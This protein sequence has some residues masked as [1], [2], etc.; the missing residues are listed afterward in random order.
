MSEISVIDLTSEYDACS[1]STK[2]ETPKTNIKIEM[3]I[4]TRQMEQSAREDAF[5]KEYEE[6][7][8]RA[9]DKVAPWLAKCIESDEETE[10][11][12]KIEYSICEDNLIQDETIDEIIDDAAGE[13]LRQTQD[14][15]LKRRAATV[16]WPR[17]L[18]EPKLPQTQSSDPKL[19]CVP[20][21]ILKRPDEPKRPPSRTCAINKPTY[22]PYRT[23]GR[24]GKKRQVLKEI[25]C[26]CINNCTCKDKCCNLNDIRRLGRT[27][28][29]G[30]IGKLVTFDIQ[31]A[32]E[33]YLK[34]VIA[35]AGEQANWRKSST[36]TPEDIFRGLKNTRI[37][38]STLRSIQD[39][40]L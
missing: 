1:T 13:Q 17:N 34:Q 40:F 9:E 22:F 20:T 4:L 14:S 36:V 21:V 7:M 19:S 8:R 15:I 24:M 5:D 23:S 37:D 3:E 27:A 12:S 2:I 28:G 33:M 31:A 25:G 30:R 38:P 35:L 11:D 16:F 32:L 29:V 18:D 39:K 26:S 10:T 6:Q